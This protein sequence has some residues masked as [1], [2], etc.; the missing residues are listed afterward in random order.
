M[1]L[2]RCSG[3]LKFWSSAMETR[4]KR[5]RNKPTNAI[6]VFV[7]KQIQGAGVLRREMDMQ[8][9]VSKP[10]WTVARNEKMDM[11]NVEEDVDT[12]SQKETEQQ[13]M[14]HFEDL[15]QFITVGSDIVHMQYC[16][17]LVTLGTTIPTQRPHG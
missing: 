17:G 7:C 9:A 10:R 2:V 12:V 8:G 15:L 4:V 3:Q 5:K 11:D 6:V 16:R 13:S 1:A 14:V